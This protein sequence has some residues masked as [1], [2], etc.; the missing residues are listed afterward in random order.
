MYHM[1]VNRFG[2]TQMVLLANV[3]QVVAVSAHFEIVLDFT[4]DRCTVCAECNSGM[5]IALGTPEWYS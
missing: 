1:H 5:E 2:H 4:Q 3:C